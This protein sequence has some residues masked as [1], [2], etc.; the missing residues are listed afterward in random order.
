M[1]W[2]WKLNVRNQGRG[3]FHVRE[4]NC[5]IMLH[6]TYVS[7]RTEKKSSCASCAN[8]VL[9]AS[10]STWNGITRVAGAVPTG[11]GTAAMA[12]TWTDGLGANVEAGIPTTS[13]AAAAGKSIWPWRASP[14]P[15]PQ[16]GT[17]GS[18]AYKLSS[19]KK[20]FCLRVERM[21]RVS[22]KLELQKLEHVTSPRVRFGWEAC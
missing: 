6:S 15:L 7:R 16:K 8:L 18:M 9:S 5:V 1:V 3:V 4:N 11:K 13:C 14:R 17:N 21:K 12:L 2:I 22:W 19:L 20:A 10:I